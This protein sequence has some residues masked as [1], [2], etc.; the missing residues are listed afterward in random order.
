MIT[1]SEPNRVLATIQLTSR[2]SIVVGL[3]VG[4][5]TKRGDDVTE[6]HELKAGEE[7]DALVARIRLWAITK[8]DAY[9]DVEV[10]LAASAGLRLSMSPV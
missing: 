9:M 1:N 4:A 6:P 2:P 8:C 10:V 5:L 7:G 3:L